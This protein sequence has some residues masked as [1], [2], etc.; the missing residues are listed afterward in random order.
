ML[1]RIPQ[2]HRCHPNHPQGGFINNQE[3]LGRQ[4]ETGK[5]LA[6]SAQKPSSYQFTINLIGLA[7][8]E[9]RRT[10]RTRGW[11]CIKN[12]VKWYQS[13]NGGWLVSLFKKQPKFASYLS[14]V[15]ISGN[16]AIAFAAFIQ[17]CKQINATSVRTEMV[18][19]PINRCLIIQVIILLFNYEKI[20][21]I[22]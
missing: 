13:N 20:R 4:Q 8:R 19:Q 5:R 1:R 9:T 6:P 12:L 10:R 21:R 18:Y 3:P 7:T 2:K 14:I 15:Q 11:I 16:S 22:L 17:L